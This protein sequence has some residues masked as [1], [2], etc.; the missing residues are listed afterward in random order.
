M[1]TKKIIAIDLGN[2]QIKIKTGMAKKNEYIFP[3]ALLAVADTNTVSLFSQGE[4]YPVFK[5][6]VNDFEENYFGPQL[7][8]IGYEENWSRSIGYGLRRYKTENFQAMLS[9]ALGLSFMDEGAGTYEVN[10]VTGLPTTDAGDPRLTDDTESK[11]CIINYLKEEQSIIINDK[12]YI[13]KVGEVQVLPQYFGLLVDRAFNKDL[14]I[15]DEDIINKKNAVLDLGGGTT[16]GDVAIG[17]SI[18]GGQQ[19]NID[20]GVSDVISGIGNAI[21]QEHGININSNNVIM[22][23]IKSRSE[24]A[25]YKYSPGNANYVYDVTPQIKEGRKQY[26]RKIKNLIQSKILHPE[27]LSNIIIGGGGANLIYM[28]DIEK[29]YPEAVLAD[30][31]E[32]AN[33]RGYY[34][35]GL[36]K[37]FGE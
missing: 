27:E 8:D 29:E 9:Y 13:I 21:A 10:I 3:T 14:T 6:E 20:S 15:A 16:L 17:L 26:T 30:E 5:T 23:M 32:L 35:F 33:V 4:D 25:G 22:D 37:E 18:K 2:D 19:F 34:K 36:I 12:T 1:K 28:E 11:R 31:S 24:E 7:R